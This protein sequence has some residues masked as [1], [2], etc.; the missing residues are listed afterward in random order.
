MLSENP[1]IKIELS[2]HTDSRGSNRYNERLSN[3]RAASAKQYL[4]ARGIAANRITAVGYGENQ[5][6]NECRDKVKCEDKQ[7]AENRRLEIKVVGL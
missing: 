2:A 1:T 5:L 4:V 7:H 6:L 3:Q